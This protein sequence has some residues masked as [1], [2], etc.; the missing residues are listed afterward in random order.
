MTRHRFSKD[1]VAALTV[2]LVEN[3]GT[4]LAELASD[5]T[6]PS[7][8]ENHPAV[9]AFH[10]L[11]NAAQ[12]LEGVVME[13]EGDFVALDAAR[14]RALLADGTKSVEQLVELFRHQER[15]IEEQ[16]AENIKLS[17]DNSGLR[18][19]NEHLDAT[20]TE[21]KQRIIAAQHAAEAVAVDAEQLAL[22]V[23]D[24]IKRAREIKLY[25]VDRARPRADFPRPLGVGPQ[26]EITR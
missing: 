20:D 1:E 17:R 11:N 16:R 23:A 2:R 19:A 24:M 9:L 25:D 12:I 13:L 6:T 21:N 4:G 7:I 26:L 15:L 8:G 14:A 5:S 18:L 10:Y 3:I 22:H